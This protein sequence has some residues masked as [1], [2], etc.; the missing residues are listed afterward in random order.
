[1]PVGYWLA[2][3]ENVVPNLYGRSSD[4]SKALLQ[5]NGFRLGAIDY[6]SGSTET[7]QRQDPGAGTVAPVDSAVAITLGKRYGAWAFVLFVAGLLAVVL[8][9][10]AIGLRMRLVKITRGLLRVQAS[11]ESK[12]GTNFPDDVQKAGP[13]AHIQARLE[14]GEARFDGDVPIVKKEVRDD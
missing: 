1:M 7:V 13:T 4:E 9:A 6:R 14:V 11:L 10:T 12:S 3:G 8:A 5:E 2:T